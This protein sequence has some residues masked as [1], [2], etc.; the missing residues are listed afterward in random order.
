MA[1]LSVCIYVPVGMAHFPM[2][3]TNCRRPFIITVVMPNTTERVLKPDNGEV[4]YSPLFTLALQ[5][6]L[7]AFQEQANSIERTELQVIPKLSARIAP[8]ETNPVTQPYVYYT[9]DP[10]VWPECEGYT[11]DPSCPTMDQGDPTCTLDPVVCTTD[12]SCPTMSTACLPP[13]PPPPPQPG[14]PVGITVMPMDKAGLL[15]PWAVGIGLLALL[16][17]GLL[18]I[19]RHTAR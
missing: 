10:I 13:Q 11:T 2:R 17:G 1:F 7:T 5:K 8:P 12:P 19:R 4:K 18:V 16:I 14:G 3:V 15:L 9:T 6:A